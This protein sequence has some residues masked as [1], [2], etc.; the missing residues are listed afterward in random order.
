MD[1]V[2]LALQLEAMGI[3][4]QNVQA[5]LR[6]KSVEEKKNKLTKNMEEQ[7]HCN[8]K[9]P[10]YEERKAKLIDRLNALNASQR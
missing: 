3:G 9:K 4:V 1:E 6:F 7:K 8:L 2:A 5:W 10:T